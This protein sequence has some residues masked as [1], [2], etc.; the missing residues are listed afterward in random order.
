MASDQYWTSAPT[1]LEQS[2]PTSH[3]CN[4][5]LEHQESNRHTPIISFD[6]ESGSYNSGNAHLV[7]MTQETT[8]SAQHQ[9]A[10]GGNWPQGAG[11]LPTC[12]PNVE[13]GTGVNYSRSCEAWPPTSSSFQNS[14]GEDIFLG[15]APCPLAYSEVGAYE[16]YQ[17]TYQSLYSSQEDTANMQVIAG[18]NIVWDEGLPYWSEPSTELLTRTHDGHA[19]TRG[20]AWNERYPATKEGNI[21][22][23]KEKDKEKDKKGEGEEVEAD[24]ASMQHIRKQ[25]AQLG[26]ELECQTREQLAAIKHGPG[27]TQPTSSFQNLG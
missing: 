7:P 3:N 26:Y 2:I 16:Y 27:Y 11:T 6:P 24:E 1:P 19:A 17:A 12:G 21:D 10:L 14:G 4:M 8:A 25:L 13:D 18:D 15:P 22:K 9:L 20:I 5:V 23:G